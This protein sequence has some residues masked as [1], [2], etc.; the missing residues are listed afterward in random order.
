L[1]RGLQDESREEMRRAWG[2]ESRQDEAGRFV[3]IVHFGQVLAD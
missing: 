3:D 1:K 2:R